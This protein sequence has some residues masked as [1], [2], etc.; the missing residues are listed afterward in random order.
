MNM[1]PKPEI[2][3]GKVKEFISVIKDSLPYPEYCCIEK[4][5]KQFYSQPF[6][7]EMI[8]EYFEEGVCRVVTCENEIISFIKSIIIDRD[9]KIEAYDNSLRV[10]SDYVKNTRA[11]KLNART[12]ETYQHYATKEKYLR[13]AL[14]TIEQNIK[15]IECSFEKGGYMELEND[16]YLFNYPMPKTLSQFI[17]NCIQ[18]NIKLTWREK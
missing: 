11:K 7:P 15:A 12:K 10:L 4:D 6:Q 9:K 3:K 14:H 5:I 8:T 16:D 1:L 17:T 2:F 18:A 13:T